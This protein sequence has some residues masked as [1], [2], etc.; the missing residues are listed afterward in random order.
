[1]RRKHRQPKDYK[2]DLMYGSPVATKFINHLMKDGKKSIARKIFY[3]AMDIIKQETNQNPLTVFDN[4]IKNISPSLEVKSQRVGGANYQV[5]KPVQGDR[6][7]TLAFRWILNAVRTKK[8]K[9]TAKKLAEEL[10]SASN[11]EGTAIKKKLDTHRMAEAN[12]AFA[13]F[14]W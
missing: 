14:S 10:I 12:R 4:A 2:P 8:G 5:P 9:M 7:I 6:K 3:D 11:N 13:H 1:M